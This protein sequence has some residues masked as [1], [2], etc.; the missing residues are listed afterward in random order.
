V[1]DRLGTKNSQ[2]SRLSS[3]PTRKELTERTNGAALGVV[4]DELKQIK[5]GFEIRSRNLLLGE[6]Q[7]EID[8]A[9]S[10]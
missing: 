5:G 8:P 10:S 4:Q 3:R 2:R 1:K 6:V 9:S 7:S